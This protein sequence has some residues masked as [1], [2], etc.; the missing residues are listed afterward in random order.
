MNS[1]QLPVEMFV[2]KW[3]CG[4]ADAVYSESPLL[5]DRPQEF[6]PYFL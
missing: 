1:N 3:C 5:V 6:N 2:G 4:L